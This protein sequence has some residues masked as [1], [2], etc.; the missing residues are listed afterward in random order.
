MTVLTQTWRPLA[1][2][3]S[4]AWRGSPLPGFFAWWWSEL[5]ACLPRRLV[6][7]LERDAAWRLLEPADGVIR[8]RR[9]GEL[10]ELAR[11]DLAQAPALQRS[12]LDEAL[13]DV[14]THD[15]R[16]AL[17]L[18]PGRVLRKRLWLPAAARGDLR[19]VAGFEIDRQTPFR[20]SEACYDVRLLGVL[21]DGRLDTELVLVPRARLTPVWQALEG[22]GVKVDAVDALADGGRL[23]VNLL[24]AD[25]RPTHPHPRKRLNLALG[26]VAILLLG[27]VMGQWLHNRRAALADMQAQVDALRD[28]ARE[29]ST[30]RRQ[31][32]DRLGAAGFL[33]RQRAGAPAV[34][35]VLAD[36]THRLP[37]DT[38]LMRLGIDDGGRLSLQGQSPHATALLK[39]LAASPYLSDPG[40][41][42]VIQ[43]DPKTHDER[44]YMT[45]DLRVPE[46]AA[47]AAPAASTANDEGGA[48][49]QAQ[50]R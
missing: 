22:M 30:L 50:A 42:G 1:G 31:L 16:L 24:D 29:V 18:P 41:Q 14:D 12:R 23:G 10:Y 36:V 32:I 38:W 47:E 43:T 33:V 19:R 7:A 6:A 21:P 20:L 3:V 37:D 15:L 39:R 49:A 28:Q 9:P 34:I 5:R 45:A 11:I 26:V 35:D 2:R 44:F 25:A 13:A 46:A 4:R 8:V 17:C 48:D 27:L 40:F